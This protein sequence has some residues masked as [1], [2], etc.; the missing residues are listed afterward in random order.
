MSRERATTCLASAGT[1]QDPSSAERATEQANAY[2]TEAV[3]EVE[4]EA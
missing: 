4:V 1:L 2:Q 3:F